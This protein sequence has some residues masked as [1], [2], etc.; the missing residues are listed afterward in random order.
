MEKAIDLEK[1]ERRFSDAL[2]GKALPFVAEETR[3]KIQLWYAKLPQDWFDNPADFED[4]TPRHAGPRT[5]MQPLK[6]SWQYALESNGFTVS[7]K[8][9]RKSDGGTTSNWGLRLQQYGGEIR[10]VKRKALTIPVTADAR[11]KRA[12]TFEKHYNRK[13][14]VVG[15]DKKMGEGTLVWEDAGGTLHAAYVLRKRAHVD[16][17]R[18]RRG[19]DAIPGAEDIAKWAT[20]AF[21]N[22][23]NF[24]LNNGEN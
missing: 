4:G 5:F 12:S 24:I 13:L 11:G 8:H 10:P 2:T 17:L 7:F 22:R 14:F 3:N 15:K 18:E 20:E 19:H 1:F 6:S 9:A 21:I 23:M 16:S